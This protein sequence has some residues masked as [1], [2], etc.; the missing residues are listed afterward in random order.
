M[1]SPPPMNTIK[2]IRSYPPYPERYG[3]IIE[4]VDNEVPC[5][6]EMESVQ[7][8]MQQSDVLHSSEF[9]TRLTISCQDPVNSSLNSCLCLS[10]PATKDASL[11]QVPGSMNHS[12]LG[13]MLQLLILCSSA[14]FLMLLFRVHGDWDRV[15]PLWDSLRTKQ[16]AHWHWHLASQPRWPRARR[17]CTAPAQGVAPH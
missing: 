7:H 2:D 1:S 6:L 12:P 10:R 3:Y 15:F 17:H 11:Q 9:G 13:Q 14:T 5:V 8:E 16:T 4:N